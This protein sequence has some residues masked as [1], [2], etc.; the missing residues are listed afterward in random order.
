MCSS[1]L[2]GFLSIGPRLT[3]PADQFSAVTSGALPANP[4]LSKIGQAEGRFIDQLQL[5][6]DQGR[7]PSTG[8]RL[9]R[10]GRFFRRGGTQR[11]GEREGRSATAPSQRVTR[12]GRTA[13]PCNPL[14]ARAWAISLAER[15]DQGVPR[16]RDRSR[17]WRCR[18]ST[19]AF[20]AS[21]R[22]KFRASPC[23]P[24]TRSPA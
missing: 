20:S 2:S 21:L 3:P 16:R 9:H 12:G 8:G 5:A 10:L 1:D 4:D 14:G 22:A 13:T 15:A 24:S 17:F 11:R 19:F 7:D 23:L 18:G 6:F